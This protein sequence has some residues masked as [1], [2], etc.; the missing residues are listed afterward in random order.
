MIQK[1]VFEFFWQSELL[2]VAKDEL[3]EKADGSQ[4]KPDI[5]EGSWSS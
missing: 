5:C 2:R 3:K 4:E 1:K